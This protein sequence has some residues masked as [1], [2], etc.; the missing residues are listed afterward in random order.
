MVVRSMPCGFSSRVVRGGHRKPP[1]PPLSTWPTRLNGSKLSHR[2]GLEGHKLNTSEDLVACSNCFTNEGLRLDAER[3]GESDSSTCPRCTAAGG[4]KLNSERLMTLAQNFFVWGS[5][6]RFKYGAA[7]AVQFNDRRKTDI[8]VPRSLRADVA[9]LEDIL[10]I[11]FF[12]YG[13]RYWMWGEIEPLKGLQD[14]ESCNEVIDRILHEYSSMKLT[15]KDQ[16]YRVRKNPSSP[17]ETS[18]YDS[19]PAEVSN[20]RL[21]TPERPALYGSPDLQTC[22]HECRVTAEDELFVAT[23]KPTRDLKLL[24]LATVLDEP[25]QVS[26][27]ESLDLAVNMLFLAGEHSYPITRAISRAAEGAGFDGLAYPSYFSM[28]RNGVKPFETTYGISHRRIPQYKEFE[29]AKISPNFAIFGR[30][31]RQGLLEVPCINRVVLST[32]IYAVHFGPVLD[33]I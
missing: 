16:F 27:F 28:L 30:P 19:A 33:T 11:G 21:D 23:L 7:P 29:E 1:V 12:S 4:P 25:R 13:P 8:E 17:P 6:R 18:Q 31:V 5:V 2:L 24:N 22:L 9:L 32:V 10:G 14:E 26:E 20:G 15:A 3:L